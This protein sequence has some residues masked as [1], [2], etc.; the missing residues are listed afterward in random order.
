M[1][2]RL[3]GAPVRSAPRPRHRRADP[4]SI[5]PPKVQRHTANAADLLP[6]LAFG[7]SAVTIGTKL[8]LLPFPVTTP[9]ELVRWLLRLAVV[10]SPDMG[11]VAGLT[12]ICVL[13]SLAA[14]GRRTATAWRWSVCAL[15]VTAAV[16]AVASLLMFRV[17]RV[18]FSIRLLSF[19]G[20]PVLMASSIAPFVSPAA[21]A[22]LV[23]APLVVLAAPLLARKLPW[24][25][26]GAPR[27]A[28]VVLAA[29]A[30]LA[31]YCGVCT[32]YIRAHWTD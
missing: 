5:E 14:R 6:S 31:V 21:V 25:H 15:Y 26:V 13:T 19:A 7:L 1:E 30:L 16:Y 4:R 29:A 18:P 10:I 11:F 28:R 27:A 17:M 20:G 8:A 22:A 2:G 24:F 3:A 9:A 12:L 23:A 32:A